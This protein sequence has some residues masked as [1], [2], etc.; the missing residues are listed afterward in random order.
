MIRYLLFF[1]II[2]LVCCTSE[3]SGNNQEDKDSKSTE[4]V[5][6]GTMDDTVGE[7]S[8][9]LFTNSIVST[10]I[11]FITDSDTDSFLTISYEGRKDKE[12]PDSRNDLLFDR[13]TF[14]FSVNFSTGATVEIW[15]HSS[16]EN[17]NLAKENADKIVN[18]LGKLPPFMLN[19]L[20]HVVLHKGNAGAFA[21]SE[22]NFFVVYSDN[23]DTR[24]ANNDFE[25]TVFH[26]SVHATLDAE[27]LQRTDWR[28]A[29]QGDGTF[30]TQYAM[31][32][33][34]KED[35]AET[36][37]FVY[38]MVKHPGRLSVD[39]EAWVKTNIPNRYNFL[40]TIFE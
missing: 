37:L 9:P 8:D 19:K 16:F 11:D 25:E 27:Y 18:R 36:A 1:F 40:K 24:I 22:A 6:D 39:V 29:Q 28:N 5:M 23:I 32:N 12:M 30:I 31:E 17:E 4:E 14:V 10:E 13:G 7:S 2:S 33:A 15:A 3:G 35:M 26:E 20:S 38:T 34:D 21:E